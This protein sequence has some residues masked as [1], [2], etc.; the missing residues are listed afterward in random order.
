MNFKK[1]TIYEKIFYLYFL[2][3]KKREQILLTLFIQVKILTYAS[4]ADTTPEPTV[5]FHRY[6][7]LIRNAQ[8]CYMI[9]VSTIQ[10]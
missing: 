5:H 4:I 9:R 10:R 6:S 7:A 3:Y 2:T 1:S 8:N